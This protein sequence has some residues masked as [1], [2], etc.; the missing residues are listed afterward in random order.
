MLAF[1]VRS[2]AFRVIILVIFSSFFL[3]PVRAVFFFNF[4]SLLS[5]C[6]YIFSIASSS[7]LY[8]PLQ[9]QPATNLAF[10]SPQPSQPH[11]PLRH[12]E[13]SPPSKPLQLFPESLIELAPHYRRT[14]PPPQPTV[15]FLDVTQSPSLSSTP[16]NNYY[17]FNP[18]LAPKPSHSIAVQ[19]LTHIYNSP[20]PMKERRVRI[21]LLF[22][23]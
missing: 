20:S 21:P 5:P 9:H 4:I 13:T 1:Y 22:H 11:H 2:V 23:C 3:L 6:C 19:E 10:S 18:H 8:H 12:R 16:Y 17:S 7:C 15:V 14:S